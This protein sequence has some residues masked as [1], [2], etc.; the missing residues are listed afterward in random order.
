MQ[1]NINM[2]AYEESVKSMRDKA[3]EFDSALT[4]VKKLNDELVVKAQQA[5]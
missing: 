5:L 3:I 2:S 1:D 4:K